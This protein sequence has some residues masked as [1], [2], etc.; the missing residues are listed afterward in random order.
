MLFFRLW[1]DE[2]PGFHIDTKSRALAG[3]QIMIWGGIIGNHIIGPFAF[4]GNVDGPSYLQMLEQ[5]VV[6]ALIQLGF[7]P[8]QVIFQHD[9]APAHFTLVV[10]DY[11]DDT[12]E[13]WIGRGGDIAWPARSPDLNPLDFFLWGHLKHE[14]YLEPPEDIDNLWQKINGAFESISPN[15]LINVR[16]NF[17]RRIDLSIVEQGGHIEQLL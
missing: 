15:M 13:A 5:N 12:F 6:P 2:N 9:G 3:E 16:N 7:A 4:E 17:I 14:V 11:L 1:C 8:D 10:R